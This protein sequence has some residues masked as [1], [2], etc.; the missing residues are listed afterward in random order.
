MAVEDRRHL[1]WHLDPLAEL[2]QKAVHD[3][4]HVHIPGVELPPLG[5]ILQQADG[6][7][8]AGIGTIVGGH[9]GQHVIPT[10]L[11]VSALQLRCQ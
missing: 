2:I 10:G 6:Q 1:T 7:A 8:G 11:K 3:S 9:L 4:D 5:G